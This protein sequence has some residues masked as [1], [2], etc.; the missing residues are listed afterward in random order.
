[1]ISRL[2]RRARPIRL[3]VLL[4][5][6]VFLSPRQ[7][8]EPGRVPV[9][10]YTV[11]VPSLEERRMEVSLLVDGVDAVSPLMI[12]SVPL[13]M[14]NPLAAAE[15][16]PVV[17]GFRAVNSASGESLGVTTREDKAGEALFEIAGP[18]KTVRI[19]YQVRVQFQES[20]QTR[21]YPIR[22]PYMNRRQAL[23]YGNYV[24]CYPE[25]G[26]D[27]QESAALGLQIN[28]DLAPPDGAFFWGVKRRFSVHNVYQLMSLHFG[29]GAYA[30]EQVPMPV[31][32]TRLSVVYEKIRDFSKSE[33]EALR[34][35]IS[36]AFEAVAELFESPPPFDHFSVLVFRDQAVGGMEGVF[37]C[38]VFAPHDLSLAHPTMART[39]NF[40]SIITHEIF[41][42]WNPI[43]F[44]GSGDP[45][46]KEG[47]TGYYGEVL[48]ARAGLVGESDLINSFQYYKRQ[49][50]RNDL[51]RKV[52]LTDPRIWDNE[53]LN[54]DWR[55]LTYERGK[56]AALLLDLEIRQ[57]TGNRR[58]LD[59]VM[60]F[61]Y[62][63]HRDRS[64]SH[65]EFESA[66][67]AATG[68]DLSEFFRDYVAGTRLPSGKEIDAAGKLIAKLGVYSAQVEAAR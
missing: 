38:Q 28:V 49:L 44:Y 11:R 37:A 32:G 36:Q 30:E 27:K 48:S 43:S 41:H 9:L 25:F 68:A 3:P 63:H 24:F 14:D 67:T 13:Y 50:D 2:T 46:I 23:L 55:T 26:K 8:P 45:W 51:I 57:K 60:R 6:L 42:A 59:D 31:G 40:Y 35:V 20:N 61:L 15:D 64:Y 58:S 16:G 47:V 54:E 4:I 18:A 29:I 52:N 56:A 66:V 1:M 39:R 19:D 5:A 22:I 62:R 33:R 65:E 53:Y 17:S 10:S 34:K 12:R 21:D 7:A